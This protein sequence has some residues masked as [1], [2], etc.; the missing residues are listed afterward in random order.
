MSEYNVQ[1]GPILSLPVRPR[2]EGDREKFLRALS[3]LAQEDPAIRIETTP[4]D[5]PTILSGMSELHLELVYDRLL[6]KFD[7]Q[8][9]IGKPTVVFRVQGLAVLRR[10]KSVPS[11]ITNFAVCAG[12]GTV[13]RVVLFFP[14]EAR[15]LER[16]PL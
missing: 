6:H 5:G 16:Q 2:S 8:L 3:V 15:V 12:A 11:V 4:E 13:V 14:G 10:K 1:N 9:D 7:L